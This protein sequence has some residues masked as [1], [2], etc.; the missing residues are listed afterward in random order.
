MGEC[1]ATCGATLELTIGT[2][3]DK[4][5][6]RVVES[7]GGSCDGLNERKVDCDTSDCPGK[8]IFIDTL[9]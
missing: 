7:C 5:T 9:L 1:S 2:R 4:R 6:K 8:V 3:V